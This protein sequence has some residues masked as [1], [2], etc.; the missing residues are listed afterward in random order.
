MAAEEH[1][2]QWRAPAR[3]EFVASSLPRILTRAQ[4]DPLKVESMA[5]QLTALTPDGEWGGAEVIAKEEKEVVVLV[6]LVLMV[7]V[8]LMVVVVESTARG[9]ADLCCAICQRR[10]S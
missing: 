8:V 1:V 3:K 7:L 6:V 4:C 2:C 9:V 5:A 10:T